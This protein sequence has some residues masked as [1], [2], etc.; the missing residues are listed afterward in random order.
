MITRGI[1]WIY[2]EVL[3]DGRQITYKPREIRTF[4]PPLLGASVYTLLLNQWHYN[5]DLSTKSLFER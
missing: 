5:L 1:V 4:K 2:T 3:T